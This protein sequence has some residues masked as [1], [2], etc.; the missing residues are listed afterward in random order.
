MGTFQPSEKSPTSARY[1]GLRLSIRAWETVAHDPTVRERERER[2]REKNHWLSWD[3]VTFS[4][5]YYSCCKTSLVYQVKM[6]YK[7]FFVSRNTRRTSHL[8]SRVLLY[9]YREELVVTVPHWCPQGSRCLSP[10]VEEGVLRQLE[11]L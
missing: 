3:H 1:H 2:E 6:Y 7:C 11:L 9:V 5:A 4:I 8:P 10:G